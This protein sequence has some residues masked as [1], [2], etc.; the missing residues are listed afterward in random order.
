M[1]TVCGL[2]KASRANANKNKRA[3]MRGKPG[4]PPRP[5]L[6]FCRQLY[7]YEF[8]RPH[9]SG[10]WNR[11]VRA[12]RSDAG[13]IFLL[14]RPGYPLTERAEVTP[15]DLALYQWVVPAVGTLRRI[16]IDAIFE[17][18][19]T[20]PH[21]HLETSSLTMSRSLL[22]SSDTITLLPRSEVQ[23]DLD[24]GVLAELR[25]PCLGGDMLVKG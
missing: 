21:F 1:R 10:T 19:Q 4:E 7:Q 13:G 5:M 14:A 9:D 12:D 16:R 17:G 15:A 25:C 23:Y 8:G 3:G 2:H 6:V 18:V 11:A 20:R 22:L 24:L